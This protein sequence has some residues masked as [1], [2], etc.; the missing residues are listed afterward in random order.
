MT[1]NSNQLAA[2]GTCTTSCPS[3]TFTSG[4]A[5][6]ACHPDCATCSGSAFNQC[7]SCPSSRPVLS[8]GRCLPTC[9]RSEFLD[10][11][12]SS[13]KACDSSCSSCTG[14]G[15]NAC[16]ACANENQVLKSGACI[17]SSCNAFT[18]VIPGLGVCLSDLVTV[19]N[20][21]SPT[22][23]PL[24][25]LT[26]Q[27][28]G[29]ARRSL[30]WWE[31]LLMA[32]GCAFIFVVILWLW[33][34]HARKQRTQQTALFHTKLNHRVAWRD[35]F[36]KFTD[37]FKG[38]KQHARSGMFVT[39][40]EYQRLQ[41]LRDAGAAHHEHEMSKLEST[42]IKSLKRIS[43]PQPSID[44]AMGHRDSDLSNRTSAPSLYSQVTGLP[45]KGPEPKQPSRELD[46]ERGVGST[47]RFSTTTSGTSIYRSPSVRRPEA[48]PLMPSEG[49][50]RNRPP[51]SFRLIPG[52][53]LWLFPFLL[54]LRAIGYSYRLRQTRLWMIIIY[55]YLL[56][57]ELWSI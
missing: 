33:R 26:T 21:T 5:C 39:E 1:C 28:T 37:F 41:R 20:P 3:N 47:S 52:D 51:T 23:Q 43:S 14:A 10:P 49:E 30:A 55:L 44:V 2:N 32:L 17:S 45:R 27:H 48:L 4:G 56:W 46:L 8:S 15:P 57:V 11:T 18:S 50:L 13:C 36:D 9:S 31:I 24:P 6:L 12:S 29:P 53:P 7:S 25:T 38:Y 16:L 22:P 42:Y 54:I 34:H 19:A 40:T 35:R